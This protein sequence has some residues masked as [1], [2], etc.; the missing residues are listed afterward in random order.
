MTGRGAID[1]LI[2]TCNRPCALAVTL[3]ALSAQTFQDFRVVISDQSEA[4]AFEKPEV[5]AVLRVIAATGRTVQA[6]RHVPW[7]GMAEQRAFLLSKVTAP[8]CLF[9][10]DDVILENDVLAR[11]HQSITEQQCGFV[12]SA[13]HGLSFIDDIRPHQQAIELWDSGVEPERVTPDGTAWARH[14]LHSAANLFHV[15]HKLGLSRDATRLYRVAWIGGCVLFD[16]QKLREAGGFDFWTALPR[17]HCG[18]DVLAQLRVM[19]RFGGC[20]MIPSGAYHMELPTTIPVRDIDAP[21][22]LSASS[23]ADT[24]WHGA[25]HSCGEE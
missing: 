8:Y 23:G 19:E 6:C 17:E 14:H 9:L 20:G 7:R 22:M 3:A 4:D 15:Q 21:K 25:A 18:E 10:D 2:P 13:L 16:T 12:G 11:L 1:V 5:A 24:H